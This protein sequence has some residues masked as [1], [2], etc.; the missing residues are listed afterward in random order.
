MKDCFTWKRSESTLEK[1][2]CCLA[3]HD[4]FSSNS[5]VHIVF[6][7]VYPSNIIRQEE[8]VR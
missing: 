8:V 4:L 3:F 2:I 5:R 1:V 7:V 6:D